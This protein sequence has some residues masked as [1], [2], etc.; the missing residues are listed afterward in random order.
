MKA[1]LNGDV[2]TSAKPTALNGRMFGKRWW[3]KPNAAFVLSIFFMFGF[4]CPHELHINFTLIFL[5]II[6]VSNLTPVFV[7]VP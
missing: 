2:M 7:Y 5:F 3:N 6:K 4:K 1:A